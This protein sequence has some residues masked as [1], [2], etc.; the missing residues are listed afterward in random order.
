MKSPL[1][2]RKKLLFLLELHDGPKFVE[3]NLSDYET[4]IGKIGP[5]VRRHVAESVLRWAHVNRL[6]VLN[7]MEKSGLMTPTQTPSSPPSCPS[8]YPV[9]RSSHNRAPL[10]QQAERLVSM[11][12]LN[13]MGIFLP[14]S[15]KFPVLREVDMEHWNF[16]VTVAGVFM[17][18]LHLRN[19][20]IGDAREE[21]LM[22][23]ISESLDEWDADGDRGFKDCQQLYESEYDRLAAAGHTPQFLASDAVGKWIVWNALGR[24]P[25]TK[26]ECML[27]RAV[28]IMV[29]EAFLDWW[30][31]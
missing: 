11:A 23:T 14:L 12:E 24:A 19:A 10:R 9:T 5:L 20:H 8:E 26:E 25:R 27:V 4:V 16:I 6:F 3:F 30:K 17:A 15:E 31:G 22:T 18:G 13:A 21:Q 28:G 2:G 29:T 7:I 1:L